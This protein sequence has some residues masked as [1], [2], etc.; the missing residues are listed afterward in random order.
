M[1]DQ[2]GHASHVTGGAPAPV[3]HS[4]V[5]FCFDVVFLTIGLRNF[6]RRILC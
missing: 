4:S 5:I 6:R 2:C 1:R 3:R